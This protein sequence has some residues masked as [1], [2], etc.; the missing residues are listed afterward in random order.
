MQNNTG[1]VVTAL[2]IFALVIAGIYGYVS[3]ILWLFQ[4]T[5]IGPI[6]LGLVGVIVA[7]LGILHGYFV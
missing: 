7:P 2:G 3:N 4:Q 5:E 1:I 6:L